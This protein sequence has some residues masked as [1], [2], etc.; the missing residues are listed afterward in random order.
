MTQSCKNTH[1]LYIQGL[2]A[3]LANTYLS[4]LN[5]GKVCKEAELH[6]D[7]TRA[8]LD[9]LCNYQVFEEAITYAYSFEILRVGE[10]TV[11]ITINIG[12]ATETYNGTGDLTEILAYFESQFLTNTDYEFEVYINEDI[13][14][15]Y[16][17][18]ATLTFATT[19]TVSS[20]DEDQATI[21][22]TNM[23]NT[24]CTIL[25]QW[26]CLTTDEMCNMICHSH[27]LLKSCN[28]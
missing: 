3:T 5:I 23:Q 28:C 26:N 16:S 9:S 2:Y 13:L 21:D 8:Y 24:Y 12:T 15:I 25:D 7:I 4:K 19:T 6:L 11:D 17:Y 20:S 27:K 14:Y 22:E 10:D 18:D 1:I